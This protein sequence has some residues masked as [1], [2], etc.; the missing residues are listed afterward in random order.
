MDG[1][2]VEYYKFNRWR[3]LHKMKTITLVLEDSLEML[4]YCEGDKQEIVADIKAALV[5]ERL[6]VMAISSRGLDSNEKRA[7]DLKQ[8]EVEM[9]SY[10]NNPYDRS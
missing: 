4:E 5:R 3:K 10:W 9:Y 2:A 1:R 7:E 6:R 8:E